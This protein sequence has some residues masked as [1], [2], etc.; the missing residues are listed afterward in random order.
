M[1]VKYTAGIV[2]DSGKVIGKRTSEAGGI[3]SVDNFESPD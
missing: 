2:D 3:P 1:E